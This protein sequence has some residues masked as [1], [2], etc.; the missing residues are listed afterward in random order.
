MSAALPISGWAMVAGSRAMMVG[1]FLGGM[2][3][4]RRRMQST[5]AQTQ[6]TNTHTWEHPQVIDGER[7]RTVIPF[8][9]AAHDSDEQKRK[10]EAY[11]ASAYRFWFRRGVGAAPSQGF[12]P[13]TPSK[14]FNFMP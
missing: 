10:E 5:I 1:T 6:L 7:G 14:I 13:C 11:T 12:H 2:Y 3:V 8:R 4:S 9:R